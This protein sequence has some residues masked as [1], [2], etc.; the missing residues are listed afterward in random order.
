MHR[1]IFSHQLCHFIISLLFPSFLILFILLKVKLSHFPA[2][3]NP[4]L[5]SSPWTKQP[6][7]A[8]RNCEKS[9][10]WL[11][12]QRWTDTA[13]QKCISR[14]NW[15]CKFK[16]ISGNILVSVLKHILS[17]KLT[18]LTQR[19]YLFFQVE[20]LISLGA[21]AT[22]ATRDGWVCGLYCVI[23]LHHRIKV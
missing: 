16:F 22:L 5:P 3:C 13:T 6:E 12:G 7:F 9:S 17:L 23:Y 14:T 18:K 1:E 4:P 2:I 15:I 19:H 20:Q 8:S 21:S 11:Y 10:Y